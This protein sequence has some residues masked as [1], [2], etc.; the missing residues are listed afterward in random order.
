MGVVLR[1]RCVVCRNFGYAVARRVHRPRCTV[2]AGLPSWVRRTRPARPTAPASSTVHPLCVHNPTYEIPRAQPAHHFMRA[3][4]VVLHP[5][6]GGRGS[7]PLRWVRTVSASHPRRPQ[8]L[9]HGAKRRDTSPFRGAEGWE[10]VYG[11]GASVYHDADTYV[12]LPPVRGGVLD[13]PPLRDC[14]GG[15]GATVRRGRLQ[16]RSPRRACLCPPPHASNPAGTAR[17]PL[18]RSVG[19][20]SS[21][22]RRKGRRGRRPLRWVR[23]I[24]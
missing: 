13:A 10:E 2:A 3:P 9:S 16:P 17:A 18:A 24:R 21:V 19:S 5:R 20:T 22:I 15:V 23:D 14:R 6:P 8:P 7:P 12:Y 1:T 4:D 11:D